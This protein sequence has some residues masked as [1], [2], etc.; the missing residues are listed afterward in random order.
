MAGCAAFDPFA[1]MALGLSSFVDCHAQALGREGFV[2]L[3]GP[4]S[5][6]GAAL[7]G[8]LTILVALIG[9]RMMLG[10]GPSLSHLVASTARV[11]LV[12]ALAA[13]W[14]AYQTLI[15]DVVLRG[16]ADVTSRMLA[17]SGLGEVTRPALAARIDGVYGNLTG[18]I[19]AAQTA[20]TP[21]PVQAAAGSSPQ[22]AAPPSPPR[23]LPTFNEVAVRIAALTLVVSSIGGFL[24]TRLAAGL[25]LA[26]GPLFLACLLLNATRG[27]FASW[28]RALSAAAL[29]AVAAACVL[30]LELA[31]LEPQAR[32][33]SALGGL[34]TAG[35][36]PGQ[37]LAT[38]GVFALVLAGALIACARAAAAARLPV[39]AAPQSDRLSPEP[40]TADTPAAPF[41]TTPL[42]APQTVAPPSRAT[43]LA[44]SIGAQQRREGHAL[45]P[46]VASRLQTGPSSQ[47][48]SQTGVTPFGQSHR[49]AVRRPASA[50]VARRDAHS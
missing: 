24:A 49:R 31:I 7:P 17:P 16:P 30:S 20:T 12:L 42:A 33:L 23:P 44:G 38:V 9:Y 22:L 13:S 4:G 21:A 11:G 1:T 5:P 46:A 41:R 10:D 37:I 50:S 48:S 32:A 47:G 3:A 26:L 29:G 36:L 8:M 34:A 45:A 27:F 14:P 43:A 2:A 39:F 28:I 15:Y 18:A 35:R 25:L 40:R 6:I 19:E